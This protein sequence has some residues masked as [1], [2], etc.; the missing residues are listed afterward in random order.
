[1][2]G[3]LV[4][5]AISFIALAA[6]MISDGKAGILIFGIIAFIVIVLF[7]GYMGSRDD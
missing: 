6:I 5:I 7:F 4:F 1:M 2:K 3:L